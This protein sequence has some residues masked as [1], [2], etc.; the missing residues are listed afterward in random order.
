MSKANLAKEI[1]IQD[2]LLLDKSMDDKEKIRDQLSLST[3]GDEPEVLKAG[4]TP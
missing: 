2:D 4:P 1:L 3:G